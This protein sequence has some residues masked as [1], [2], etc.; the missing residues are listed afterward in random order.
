MRRTHYTRNES[1]MQGLP[2][3]W[4][5]IIVGIIL[6][7]VLIKLF[8]SNNEWSGESYLTVTP[9][10]QS[11]VYITMTSAS[12]ARI[13]G[14]QKLF[15]TDKSVLVE[16]GNA[17]AENQF[18]K[19]DI[20]R[21]SELSYRLSSQTGN[22]IA[23]IAGRS[24][25]EVLEKSLIA[26]LTNYSIEATPGSLLVIEQ[27]WPYSNVYALRNSI[28]INT[29]AGNI[30][31]P[32][33]KMI[34][35]LKSDLLNPNTKI[36]DWTKNIDSSTLES[37]LFTRNGARD[38]VKDTIVWSGM[39]WD[40]DKKDNEWTDTPTTSRY[41][42]ITE[43]KMWS[44]IRTNTLSVMGNLLSKDVKRVTINNIDATVSPVN[45]TFV[46]QNIPASGEIIDL[47]YKAFDVNNSLLESWVIT[48]YGN[49]NNAGSTTL[50]PETFPV[51][52][53]DFRITFPSSNPFITTDRLVRVEGSIPTNT[54]DYITVNDFRLQKFVPRSWSWYYFANMEFGTMKDGL[55]L[56]TIKFFRSDGTLLFTQPLTII[57]ESRNATVSGE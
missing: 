54:V 6:I 31:L 46:L 19:I 18:L 21:S 28:S 23:L 43:P 34:S 24:W 35:L 50:V 26:E 57:K 49:K 51:S 25:I 13:S 4:I 52:G 1:S 5:S 2:W 40:T 15:A 27:N 55:N 53:R 9:W 30:D 39:D 7:L 41:I 48:I 44:M 29:S 20:D 11:A 56:Y 33:W 47:V 45:E 8:A 14:A 36:E 37:P 22:T 42:E 17:L 32:A 16:S 10:E 12:K 38:I 3:K